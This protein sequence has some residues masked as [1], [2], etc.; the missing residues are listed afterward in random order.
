MDLLGLIS[1]A[2]DAGAS[3][4]HLEA[5]LPPSGRIRGRLQA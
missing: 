2:R 1:A 5:G 3:D 4:L